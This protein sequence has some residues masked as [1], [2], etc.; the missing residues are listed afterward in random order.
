M[1]VPPERLVGTTA[2]FLLVGV[3]CLALASAS[4]YL[5]EARWLRLKV[6]F[7]GSS[8]ITSENVSRQAVS[9]A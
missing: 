7:A 2:G 5:W 6:R 9:L 3:T 1:G 8:K 4:W